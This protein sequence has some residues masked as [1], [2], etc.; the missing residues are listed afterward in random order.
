MRSTRPAPRGMPRPAVLPL[1]ATR[2]ARRRPRALAARGFPVLPTPERAARAVA[3]VVPRRACS[4]PATGADAGRSR[5]ARAGRPTGCRGRGRGQGAGRRPGSLPR[6]GSSA[7][8]E[9]RRR[10]RSERLGRPVAVKV[11]DRRRSSTSP[12]SAAS[13]SASR[14]RPPSRSALEAIDRHRGRALPGRAGG[15]PGP[16]LILGEAGTPPSA[17]RWSSARAGRSVDPAPDAGRPPCAG[18]AA[19]RDRHARGARGAAA[20]RAPAAL[21]PSTRPA[22]GRFDRGV[23][24]PDRPM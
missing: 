17:R 3:A 14:R 24:R 9:R 13:T 18:A 12:R 15:P 20:C 11:L 23:R 10:P 2:W 22:A 8:R 16:E 6:P 21:R 19:R 4:G 5:R 1:T 7:P